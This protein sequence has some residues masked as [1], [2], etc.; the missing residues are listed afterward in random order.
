VSKSII[1]K[2]K[3]DFDEAKRSLRYHDKTYHWDEEQDWYRISKHDREKRKYLNQN[4]ERRRI[5]RLNEILRQAVEERQSENY[6]LATT[7][8]SVTHPAPDADEESES[9]H[10][11]KETPWQKH[12]KQGPPA[13]GKPIDRTKYGTRVYSVDGKTWWD[14]CVNDS[15]NYPGGTAVRLI[16]PPPRKDGKRWHM[17]V[18]DLETMEAIRREFARGIR[19]KKK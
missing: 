19:P 1:Q 11:K 13:K 2:Y 18:F 3:V 17:G 15:T 9:A 5:G 12:T 14:I 4:D 16:L 10:E 8:E 6:D 7:I